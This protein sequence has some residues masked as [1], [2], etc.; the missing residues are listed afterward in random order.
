MKQRTFGTL[1]RLLMAT[2]VAVGSVACAAGG[3]FA[4]LDGASDSVTLRVTNQVGEPVQL[5]YVFGRAVPTTLGTVRANAQAE[6]SLRF[7]RAGDLRLSGDFVERRTGTS[8]A[9]MD[10]QPGDVLDLTINQRKE[11]QLERSSSR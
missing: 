4:G 8:N 1:A 3:T 9:I 2:A 11:L 7:S 6:Y 10:L 5:R